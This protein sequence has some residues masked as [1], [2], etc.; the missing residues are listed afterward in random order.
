MCGGPGWQMDEQ[1]SIDLLPVLIENQEVRE[2]SIAGVS[3]DL[4]QGIALQN[5]I[6]QLLQ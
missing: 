3:G 2:P 4:L 6:V 5:Y 1:Q